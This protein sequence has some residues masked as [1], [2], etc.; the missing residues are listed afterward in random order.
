MCHTAWATLP[1][2]P[3]DFRRHGLAAPRCGRPPCPTLMRAVRAR[4]FGTASRL[5]AQ[6][7]G[8]S[9]SVRG[10]RRAG[11]M[12][13]RSRTAP[14]TP[15]PLCAHTMGAPWGLAPCRRGLARC[16]SALPRAFPAAG[17]A[18]M[19]R[20]PASCGAPRPSP[21]AQ[22]LRRPASASSHPQEPSRVHVRVGYP[23]LHARAGRLRAGGPTRWTAG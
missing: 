15:R 2:P 1:L 17:R 7:G 22:N 19:R 10:D 23:T 14:G 16:S 18:G 20:M 12:P 4:L 6:T 9:S 5:P 21:A 8:G 11:T 13:P 3:C